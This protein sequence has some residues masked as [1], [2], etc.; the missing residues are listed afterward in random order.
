MV[1]EKLHGKEISYNNLLDI[2]AATN[3]LADFKETTFAILKHNNPCGAASRGKLIDAWKDALAGDPVSAFGGILITNEQV[4]EVT[5]E[6][7]NKLFF[8]V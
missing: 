7:I 4:D 3:L 8:E 5:A 2:D 1:F 6:E